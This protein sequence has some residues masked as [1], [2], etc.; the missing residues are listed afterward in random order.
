[1]KKGRKKQRTLISLC[2]LICQ[3]YDECRAL[4]EQSG[5]QEGLASVLQEMGF[6]HYSI[7]DLNKA[8]QELQR[9]HG[10]YQA[11][12]SHKPA[13]YNAASMIRQLRPILADP[14]KKLA[15]LGLSAHLFLFSVH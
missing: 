8:M 2:F 15:F 4:R 10:I 7:G 5:N 1:M 6:L 9:C 11:M 3:L 13:F 14:R 12:H